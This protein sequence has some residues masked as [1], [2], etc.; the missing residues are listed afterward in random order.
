[1]LCISTTLFLAA[2]CL[3][4]SADFPTETATTCEGYNIH[5]LSC[6][7]LGVISVQTA[8]Y[9]RKDRV[10]C[11]EGM[12]TSK[13]ENLYCSLDGVLDIIK[14]RCDGKTLCE[15]NSNAFTP[16]PCRGTYKYLQTTYTCLPSTTHVVCENSLAHLNC[17]AGQVISVYGADYGRH[18]RTTCI[19]KLSESKIQNT[20]CY[21]PTNIV[22]ESCN[23]KNSCTI[24]ASNSVFG[25]PCSGTYKYLEVSY[26]CEYPVTIMIESW[27]WEV[28]VAK[29][30]Q[31]LGSSA[32]LAHLVP[33]GHI[34]LKDK[35]HI[36]QGRKCQKSD[37]LFGKRRECRF[38]LS[39]WKNHH[40][41]Q[42][43]SQLREIRLLQVVWQ[44]E[45]RQF[46][47][48][49]NKYRCDR[50]SLHQSH[51]SPETGSSE[52]MLRFSLSAALL[53]A[54]TCLFM[55]AVST[56][57]VLTCDSNNN[58]QH[59]SCDFGVISVQA[60]LYGRADNETCSEWITEEQLDTQCSQNGTTDVLRRRCDG[61]KVCEINANV[62]GT[63][64]PCF[65]VHKYLETIYT[66][67]PA[68]H[69]VACERS[70]AHLFCDV[71]QVIFVLGAD[72]GRRD[73][74]TCS[75]RRPERQIQNVDCSR[76]TSQV[77]DSCNGKNSCTIRANNSV[78]GDPCIGTYKYLE[79]SYVCDYPALAPEEPVETH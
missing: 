31:Y 73:Q 3:L 12:S 49:Q 64:D 9:G 14:K 70:L 17:A 19:Y 40:D 2:T 54:A 27:Y 59:L 33:W 28:G 39:D 77:A 22:A 13:T 75:F 21:N 44:V 8:L 20:D 56:E 51:C 62:I 6:A 10:I 69:V 24:R 38:L 53:L 71:G 61:K 63:S 50:P 52:T 23:G 47:I 7:G 58:V 74:A 34:H 48:K 43:L 57:R 60:A 29:G 46:L 18:D 79:V 26:T 72:Y 35:G 5:R 36:L 25:D 66:C 67:F 15:M 68:I 1:M 37:C 76:P 4:A 45:R 41:H 42:T 32:H 55:T 78:F 30:R 65:G 16:D 11:S